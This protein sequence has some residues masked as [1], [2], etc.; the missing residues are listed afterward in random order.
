MKSKLLVTFFLF[1]TIA[2]AQN[3]RII[4]DF[5]N[6]EHIKNLKLNKL[7]SHVNVNKNPNDVSIN[8]VLK[9]R[10]DSIISVDT[11]QNNQTNN[12]R[13]SKNVFIY[14][15]N[16]N[17]TLTQEYEKDTLGNWKII[18]KSDYSFDGAGNLLND[19]F[20]YVNLNSTG[21]INSTK[22]EYTYNVNGQNTQEINY[23]WDTNLNQ[24]KLQNKNELTYDNNGKKLQQLNFSWDSNVNQ[25]NLTSKS[26]YFYNGLNCI[27]IL[28]SAWDSTAN[29]W[30]A[31]SK[32]DYTYNLNG[33]VT[34]KL[35][36]QWDTNSTQ[37]TASYKT[38]YVYDSN[39]NV[40]QEFGSN[41]NSIVGQWDTSNKYEITYNNNFS[42]NQLLLPTSTR[43][44]YDN[45]NYYEHM[46]TEYRVFN[47]DSNGFWENSW[48]ANFYYSEQNINA[49]NAIEK[50]GV[51]IYP[52]PAK[53]Y[54][55]INLNNNANHILFELF[56]L[57]G[58][59]LISKTIGKKETINIE[60]LSN[61]FYLYSLT[62]D[63]KKH[64]GKIVKND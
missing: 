32:N 59:R 3:K 52:N 41:W 27:Q 64:T 17:N 50:L 21:W 48:L 10:L 56:N 15:S 36:S 7:K 26:D 61:G 35:Y 28:N 24:W 14:D 1:T 25:W 40:I 55:T 57:Q 45:I 31:N 62:V 37:W 2:F 6:N 53:N 43:Q 38:E 8:N 20:S 22:N 13:Y 11:I 5:Q 23:N 42:F 51:K 47:L 39:D 58:E 34:Q 46:V 54:L 9:Q 30:V 29:Q 19:I 12:I 63:G 18:T 16:G 44:Y 33:K 4:G 49:L 60:H